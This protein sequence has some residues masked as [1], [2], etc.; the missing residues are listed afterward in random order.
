MATSAAPA[1]P[2]ASRSAVCAASSTAR[3]KSPTSVQ[4]ALASHTCQNSTA[5]TSRGTRSAVRVSSAPNEVTRT[6][7]STRMVFCSI[8]GMVQ[9]SPG[10]L[11]RLNLPSRSTTTF[12]HCCAICTDDTANSATT[13]ATTTAITPMDPVAICAAPNT[14]QKHKANRTA[15]NR[16]TPALDARSP[17]MVVFAPVAR[18]AAPAP[19]P[20]SAATSGTTRKPPAFA[21]VVCL[22]AFRLPPISTP[23]SSRRACAHPCP[24]PRY[25]PRRPRAQPRRPPLR[26]S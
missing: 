26:F 17:A 5:F 8:T 6:R 20:A 3:V 14:M 9:N 21:P 2:M 16:T 10:P 11:T 24:L 1:R 23:P 19:D 13:R 18:L 12:S 22:P 4:A 25:A 7:P 15:E